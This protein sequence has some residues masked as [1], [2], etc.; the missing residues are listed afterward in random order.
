MP[1]AAQNADSIDQV[2]M[3][4][5]F[6]RASDTSLQTAGS[7]V[8]LLVLKCRTGSPV[9]C[10]LCC[11]LFFSDA[12]AGLQLLDSALIAHVKCLQF[13]LRNIDS[14]HLYFYFYA[15]N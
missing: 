6:R 12:I 9:D 8:G 11:L 1:P 5:D 3:E 7:A 2:G 4:E 10:D 15:R 14:S 13:R